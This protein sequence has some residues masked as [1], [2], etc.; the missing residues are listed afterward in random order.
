MT[1]QI[2]L[3]EVSDLKFYSVV[4]VILVCSLLISNCCLRQTSSIIINPLH[5][6]NARMNDVLKAENF[7]DVHFN[8][9]HSSCHEIQN[10]QEQFSDLIADYKFSQNDFMNQES[11]VIALIDL[12]EACVLFGGQNYTALG[13]CYNN[14]ANLHYKHQ[15]Y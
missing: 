1:V 11:D 14:M 6:L 4:F 15:K 7:N 13:M 3:F 10:L 5:R 2:A 12:A 8:A 9:G